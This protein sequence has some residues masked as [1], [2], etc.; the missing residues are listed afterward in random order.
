VG[1]HWD[2]CVHG[3]RLT[4]IRSVVT[5]NILTKIEV[6]KQ[7]YRVMV[8]GFPN[9]FLLTGPNTLPSGH[10]T[11]LSIENS[12]A[13]I[14]RLLEPQ[15]APKSPLS[16]TMLSTIEV[17]RSAEEAFNR[18]LEYRLKVSCTLEALVLGIQMSE[19]GKTVSFGQEVSWNSGGR[20][21]LRKLHG[22]ISDFERSSH[23]GWYGI[24]FVA[25]NFIMFFILISLLM[26][27]SP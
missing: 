27:R 12:V 23:A 8:S 17:T 1:E 14:L 16:Q 26:L 20:D 7:G 19:Q 24:N 5:H 22:L 9:L 15:L 4:L 2:K 18:D 25:A 3:V 13:Y 6:L 10:S 11:L 21:V